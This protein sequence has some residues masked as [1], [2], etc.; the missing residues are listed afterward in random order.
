[1][2]GPRVDA[3]ENRAARRQRVLKQGKILLSNDMTVMGAS[4]CG[5]GGQSLGNHLNCVYGM[6]LYAVNPVPQRRT[7]Q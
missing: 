4:C 3:E 6:P 2:S 1:M 5:M 7:K